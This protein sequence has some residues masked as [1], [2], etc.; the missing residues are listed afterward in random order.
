[1]AVILIVEDDVFIREIAVMMIEDWGHH[2]PQAA[3]ARRAQ[4][5][6]RNLASDQ[7]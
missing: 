6:E 5:D 2:T 7:E 4:L 3:R 1:M